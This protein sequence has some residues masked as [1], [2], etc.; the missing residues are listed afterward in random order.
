MENKTVELNEDV[1][2]EVFFS[3]AETPI[4]EVRNKEPAQKKKVKVKSCRVL[5][6]NKHSNILAFMFDDTP[7]QLLLKKPPKIRGEF[8][9]IKYSGDIHKGDISFCF[10]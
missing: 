8:V 6:Y 5:S 3:V 10:D 9:P 1:F 7:C 4:V 2:D